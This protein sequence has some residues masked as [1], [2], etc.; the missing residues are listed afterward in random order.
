VAIP[1]YSTLFIAANGE[2]IAAAYTVPAGMTAIVRDVDVLFLGDPG[3]T[4]FTLSDQSTGTYVAY[5][6]QIDTDQ[7]YSWRGRQVFPE[8]ATFQANSAGPN[9]LTARVSGYLLTN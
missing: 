7:L 9:S 5:C 1:V 2:D 4:A 6:L 3:D 8:G